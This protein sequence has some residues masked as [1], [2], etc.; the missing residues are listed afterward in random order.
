MVADEPVQLLL[1]ARGFLLT[2]QQH[3]HPAIDGILDR[4][5]GQKV[6]PAE[7]FGPVVDDATGV[8]PQF[9]LNLLGCPSF[10]VESLRRIADLFGVRHG[11]SIR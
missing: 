11:A 1:L 5:L 7:L 4:F 6:T 10:K 9:V 2:V 8:E 3:L